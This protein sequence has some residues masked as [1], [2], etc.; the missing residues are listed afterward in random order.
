[1]AKNE[2]DTS[3]KMSDETHLNILRILTEEPGINQ[4][5]GV[6]LGRD[7]LGRG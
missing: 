6:G 2:N 7:G 4:R 1:M 3:K 5:P